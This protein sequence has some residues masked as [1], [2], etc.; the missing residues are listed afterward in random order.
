MTTLTSTW[1]TIGSVESGKILAMTDG[2]RVRVS[3][4]EDVDADLI[5]EMLS[6]K[7]IQI[8]NSPVFEAGESEGE[9]VA[10]FPIA[11]LL[12]TA[13]Q[14][15]IDRLKANCDYNAYSGLSVRVEDGLVQIYDDYASATLPDPAA[16]LA[17]LQALEPIDWVEHDNTE[18]AF[19]PIWDAI[20]IT[21]G[22]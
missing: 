22:Y 6:D 20:T 19:E 21:G 3:F 15:E 14:S 7:G 9:T 10:F 1:Q 5:V 13:I 11:Q 12:V 16:T 8:E 4:P 17:A 18:T 2:D